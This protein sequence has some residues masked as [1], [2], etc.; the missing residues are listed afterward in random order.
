V[1]AVDNPSYTTAQQSAPSSFLQRYDLRLNLRG[2]NGAIYSEWESIT[3]LFLQMQGYDAT[4]EVLPWSAN[5][6]NHSPPIVITRITQVFFDLHTYIPGLAST[7]ASLRSRLELGDM[8]HP[9]I[10]LRSSVPPTQL[11][12]KLKPWMEAT[13]QRMWVR[14]VPLVEQTRCIGWLLYSAPE[15]NLVNLHRQ[16]KMDTGINVEFRFRSIADNGACRSDRTA[17][18]IKAIHLEVDHGITPSQLQ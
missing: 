8:R 3:N 10:L 15:Y 18:R 16:I 12:D 4:I 5:D 14:Q 17:S 11:A 6:Q 2:P 7:K 13:K 9:S 1:P